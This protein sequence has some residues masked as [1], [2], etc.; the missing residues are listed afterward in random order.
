MRWHKIVAEPKHKCSSN[1]K[2]QDLST[3]SVAL[4]E[5]S[6]LSLQFYSMNADE[7]KSFFICLCKQTFFFTA[8]VL[9]KL[10]LIQ[11]K[12]NSETFIC[13]DQSSACFQK[14]LNSD[15]FRKF[16]SEHD[17]PLC[18]QNFCLYFSCRAC[19]VVS[20]VTISSNCLVL[21]WYS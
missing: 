15:K 6:V 2:T 13:P 9:E 20:C 12:S 14:Y 21:S 10:G 1:S 19:Q 4:L 18:Y 7:Q 8:M 17:C 3:K 16:P 5:K 11:R